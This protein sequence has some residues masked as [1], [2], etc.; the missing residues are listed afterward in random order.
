MYYTCMFFTAVCTGANTDAPGGANIE[1]VRVIGREYDADAPAVHSPFP[2]DQEK[3]KNGAVTAREGFV[4]V[5]FGKIVRQSRALS[6]S[7]VT[8]RVIFT[9]IMTPQA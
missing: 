9:R 4:S 6:R 7:T 5:L 2:S 1:G 3:K 8:S